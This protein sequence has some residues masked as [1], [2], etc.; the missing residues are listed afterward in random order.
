MSDAARRCCEVSDGAVCR[1]WRALGRVAAAAAGEPSG[2]AREARLVVL[3]RAAA[4]WL[5][6]TDAE[7]ADEAG[8]VCVVPVPEHDAEA[9]DAAEALGVRRWA[10]T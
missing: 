5:L 4:W 2:R 8:G 10:S 3:W 7:R 6:C 9:A 1:A